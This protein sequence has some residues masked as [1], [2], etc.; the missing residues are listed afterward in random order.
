MATSPS[1]GGR[2]RWGDSTV[3]RRLYAALTVEDRLDALWV[4]QPWRPNHR[5]R[6]RI[7]HPPGMDVCAPS[8]LN[9][10]VAVLSS[11]YAG[12]HFQWGTS[13]VIG[14]I[15]IG[16]AQDTGWVGWADLTPFERK[17]VRDWVADVVNEHRHLGWPITHNT[18]G[19]YILPDTL[20]SSFDSRAM[21]DE[22][23]MLTR[24]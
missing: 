10:I 15:H 1:T 14:G 21:S 18:A 19:R 2:F 16:R 9:Q 12:V 11:G 17:V 3:S 13:S 7:P 5:R 20:W 8:N 23:G 22:S 6:S 24:D 4:N